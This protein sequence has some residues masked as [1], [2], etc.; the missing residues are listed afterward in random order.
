MITISMAHRIDRFSKP[1]REIRGAM[2]T[3]WAN[4]LG[5]HLQKIDLSLRQTPQMSTPPQ[6][7]PPY[8]LNPHRDRSSHGGA[9]VLI[10]PL[11]RARSQAELTSPLGVNPNPHETYDLGMVCTHPSMVVGMIHSWVSYIVPDGTKKLCLEYLVSISN[12]FVLTSHLFCTA[13]IN[14]AITRWLVI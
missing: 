12:K 11:A 1:A 13:V 10:E 6:L 7:S 8:P 14:L 5:H 3:N 9:I 4:V 2:F